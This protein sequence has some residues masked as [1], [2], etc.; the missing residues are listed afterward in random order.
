MAAEFARFGV[1]VAMIA[2]GLIGHDGMHPRQKQWMA[3]RLP[4][5]RLGTPRE[6]A[7][8]AASSRAIWPPTQADASFR[9]LAAGTGGKTGPPVTT[10]L[11]C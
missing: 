11:T 7:N 9:S 6:V 2:P 5:G 8:M 1:R 10:R 3:E 4:A